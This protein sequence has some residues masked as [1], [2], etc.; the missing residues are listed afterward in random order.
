MTEGQPRRAI[1]IILALVLPI[2]T[3]HYYVGL[4]RR[5]VFW[6]ALSALGLLV[7]A[8]FVAVSGGKLRACAFGGWLVFFVLG[9]IGPVVDLAVIK[10]S[11]FTRVPTARVVAFAV[12][13]A[14]A[15][16][17]VR[18]TTRST[19]LEAFKIP[20]AAMA[21]TLL[22]GDHIFV[23]KLSYGPF[24]PFTSHRLY[25]GAFPKIGDLIVFEYP[26]PDSTAPR[27]DYVKRVV[28]VPG[29][30][31]E[32]D[33]GHP[34]INGWRVPS[35]LVGQHERRDGN[36]APRKG[37]VFVEF[38]GDH[39]FLTWFDDGSDTG[40]Q[41]PY[42]VQP[43]EIWVLGDNRNNSSDSR[44][45]NQGLGA[46]VPI[47][48]V[49]GKALFVWLGFDSNGAVSW[50]HIGRDVDDLPVPPKGDRD[51]LAAGIRNCLTQRPARTVPP[52][53]G[54]QAH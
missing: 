42:V 46:G 36:E 9:W 15:G 3:G 5:A 43:G 18:L 4:L 44:Y 50:D 33:K 27:Q 47:R 10:S 26:N 16:F 14:I 12:L 29:D 17:G 23:S 13:V 39:S 51:P 30:T 7:S 40:K 1:G 35:C 25:S 31:L 53:S 45:W 2:G 20:S 37:S 28:A 24:F 41:G 22:P 32:L 54:E 48:L 49:K 11:R 8:T 19:L 21:P 52:A 34:V 38:L 6:F